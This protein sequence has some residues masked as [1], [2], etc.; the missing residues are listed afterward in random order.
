MVYTSGLGPEH[1]YT[2][3]GVNMNMNNHT[4]YPTL[5]VTEI[6]LPYMDAYTSEDSRS[7][8]SSSVATRQTNYIPPL[9]AS[10]A[11]TTET[12]TTTS[13]PP[14]T[15]PSRH[16]KA[17]FQSSSGSHGSS[18]SRSR[19]GRRQSSLY[20]QHRRIA[21]APTTVS[22]TP[23]ADQPSRR[24]DLLALHRESCRLFQ[25][26][27]TPTAPS[28]PPRNQ[29]SPS[30]SSSLTTTITT[31][32]SSPK[33]SSPFSA[34]REVYK[35]PVRASTLPVWDRADDATPQTTVT[36]IDWTSPST[37]RREYEKIDKASSGV[38]GFWRR[39]APKWCQSRAR[40]MP[41]FEEKDGKGNYE[42]SVRRFRMDIPE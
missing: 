21:T 18:S 12:T 35:T 41:F 24:E 4:K 5:A 3:P 36:V 33:A 22:I 26:P 23:I 20:S 17:S 9:P 15:S 7:S 27:P 28:T 39:V 13:S 37:R 14:S 29:R 6:S 38:R 11:A 42:G 1:L 31:T 10:P 30:T 25:Q 40:R 2:S 32:T 34:V 19:R 8:R 16:R